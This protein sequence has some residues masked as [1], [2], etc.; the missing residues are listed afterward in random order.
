MSIDGWMG[1]KIRYIHTVEYYSA[2]KK[3]ESSH[4]LQCKGISVPYT[5][6]N[7]PVTK[8]HCMIPNIWG[9]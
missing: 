4:I 3:K 8:R 9:K 5:K 1:K 7:K 2:L 6:W